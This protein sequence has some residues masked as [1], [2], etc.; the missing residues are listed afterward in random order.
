MNIATALLLLAAQQTPTLPTG[1]PAPD[2]DLPGVDG[3]RYT[4]KDFASAKLLLI[5]FN[6][7]HCPTAQFYEERIKKVGDD[8]RDKGLTLVAINPNDPLA[9]RPDELGYTDLADGF[10]EMK[11]RARD[12]GYNYPYL[13]DGDTQ[14][15]A[16]AYGPTATPHAFLFD[17]D[18]KLRY[19]GRID[20]NEKGDHIMAHDLR[21]AIDA[22]LAGREPEVARTKA[23]GC[24]LKWA[25]KR[26]SVRKY[27]ERIA[28]EPVTLGALRDLQRHGEAARKGKLTVIHTW[29]PDHASE[30]PKL[31]AMYHW[32]R[33]RNFELVTIAVTGMKDEALA[34]LRK[35][36]ASS[37]NLVASAE[38]K[39]LPGP[40]TEILLP[41]GQVLFSREGALDDLEVKRIIVANLK[42][43][44]K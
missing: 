25:D 31:A 35:A 27:L 33:R 39:P 11:I 26:D 3:R 19:T 43:D 7:N 21:N 34:G 2:F 18:R 24:S 41:S 5:I 40:K 15:T 36:C 38:G 32:Y 9:V 10:E 1:A 6:T 37:A 44:R 22:L 29:S 28:A 12:R 42:E 4:L 14:A 23:N 17:A 20:D 16:R 13:H 30:I 8:Y